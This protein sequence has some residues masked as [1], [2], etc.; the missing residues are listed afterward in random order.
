MNDR[1]K[2]TPACYLILKRD[3][4]VLL[5]RRQGSGYFDG[6]YSLP[7]GHI[8]EGEIP[9]ECTIRETKEEIGVEVRKEDLTL[10]HTMYRTKH[11]P[12]GDRADYFFTTHLW[13]GEPV[14]GEPEKCDDLA[15]FP[16]TSLPENT[17]PHIRDVIVGIEKGITYSEL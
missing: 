7:A 6:W 11:D 15:W 12:T 1:N 10:V 3:D 8:E 4:K 9:T 17:I 2:A 16:I 14:I 5:L 13:S